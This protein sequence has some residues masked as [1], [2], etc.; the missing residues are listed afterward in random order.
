MIDIIDELERFE[1]DLEGSTLVLRRISAEA[2]ARLAARHT[3]RVKTESGAWETRTDATAVLL[4]CVDYAVTA[5]RGVR[6]PVTKEDVPCASEHKRRLPAKILER[7]MAAVGEA[8]SAAADRCGAEL[9]DLEAFLKV[10]ADFPGLDCDECRRRGEEE[11]EQPDCSSC[12][13]RDL[14]PDAVVMQALD[15]I[16]A[17]LFRE[18]PALVLE[19]FRLLLPPMTKHEAA[20]FLLKLTLAHQY[21]LASRSDHRGD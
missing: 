14:K 1:L 17:P 12:P 19:A 15:L 3:T 11:D 7:I 2:H 18:C 21:E 4:D 20:V 9:V 5:W 6:H 8:E 16:R 13:M 10:R